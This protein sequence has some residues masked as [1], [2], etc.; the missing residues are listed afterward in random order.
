MLNSDFNPGWISPP[1]DSIKDI[2]KSKSLSEQWLSR[3]LDIDIGTCLGIING[4]I[5]INGTIAKKISAVLGGSTDFWLKREE[6]YKKEIEARAPVF[7]ENF[8]HGQYHRILEKRGWVDGRSD[9]RIIET[10]LEFFGVHDMKEWTMRYI[11]VHQNYAFKT[12]LAME[13]D[14]V[15]TAIWLRRGEVKAAALDCGNFDR[16]SLINSISAIRA[17][18]R[19]KH[20]DKFLPKLQDILCRCGVALVI[21]PGVAECRASGA[22]RI[23]RNGFAIIVLSARYKTDDHLWFALFHEIGH[24]ILHSAG[25]VNLEF[26]NANYQDVENPDEELEA[27]EFAS[28]TLIPDIFMPLLE[29]TR[30]EYSEIIRLAG[31]IGIS[32]GILVGQM[33]HKKIISYNWLNKCK[34][35]YKWSGEDL[36]LA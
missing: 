20:P 17:L 33:Q 10:M 6:I 29:N 26:D 19:E 32:P 11:H 14:P 8:V 27:N 34:R 31:E 28:A 30:H 35:R 22:T 12:S 1:G 9:G 23:H 13:S 16:K 36:L 25:R 7:E 3:E 4:E 15:S 18:T 2:L 5:A 21:V 24:L